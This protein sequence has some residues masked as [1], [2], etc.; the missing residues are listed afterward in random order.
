MILVVKQKSYD[1]KSYSLKI[2]LSNYKYYYNKEYKIHM[3]IELNI[4]LQIL[5]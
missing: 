1:T 4:I 3:K 5:Q 2:V